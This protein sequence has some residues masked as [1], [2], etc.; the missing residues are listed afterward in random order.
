M[1]AFLNSSNWVLSLD[2]NEAFP[3]LLAMIEHTIGSTCE[4]D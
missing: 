4:G 1:S 2:F 3:D